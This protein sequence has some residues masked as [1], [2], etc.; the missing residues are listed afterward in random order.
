MSKI[1]LSFFT[2]LLQPLTFR[3]QKH[4]REIVV[5]AGELR[6]GRL[7]F[8]VV[9]SEKVMLLQLAFMFMSQNER[10]IVLLDSRCVAHFWDTNFWK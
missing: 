1:F 2:E 4:G 6:H 9:K 10:G 5:V 3:A 8:A 7:L